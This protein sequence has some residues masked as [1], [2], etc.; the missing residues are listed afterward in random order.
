[1]NLYSW[2]LKWGVP[3]AALQDLDREL[4]L[5]D[6]VIGD[7]YG[8]SEAAA[9]AAV[10]LEAASKGMRLWRNNVGA[11]TDERGVPIRFGLAN[12]SAKI[13]KVIK[14]G[15]L[16]GINSKP[17]TLA[18]VGQPRG[19][20]LSR[21]IKKPGWAYSAT[22]HEQAQYRWNLLVCAAGGDACFATGPGTL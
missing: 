15:D 4:G 9:Q 14:S 16:I 12:D 1:M 10:R 18:E 11:L 6:A 3:L 8:Q 22:P 20:F 19:Q 2:A 17:I 21:E 13:N 7:S 5:G